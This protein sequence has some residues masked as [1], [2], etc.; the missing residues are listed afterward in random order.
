MMTGTAQSPSGDQTLDELLAE[1]I[2]QQLMRAD[3]TD[4]AAIR[5][6][7][8]ETAG[9]CFVQRLSGSDEADEATIRRCAPRF[10]A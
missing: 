3:R 7:L 6:L 5:H 2:V 10:R 8:Q 4:E 9:R 1:P